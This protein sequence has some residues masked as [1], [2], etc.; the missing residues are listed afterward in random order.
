MTTNKWIGQSVERLEDPPLVK[1]CG[2]FAGDITF[3]HQLHMRVVRSNNAHGKLLSVDLFA[4][5]ET[6]AS[7]R[8]VFILKE[9]ARVVYVA[10]AAAITARRRDSRGNRDGDQR[11]KVAADFDLELARRKVLLEDLAL[12]RAFDHAMVGR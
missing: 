1:G 2:R 12:R 7:G 8:E 4:V 6:A 5:V 9:P 11:M 3:P 10:V